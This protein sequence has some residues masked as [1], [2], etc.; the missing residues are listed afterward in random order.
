MKTPF[1]KSG[2]HFALTLSTTLVAL[3]GCGGGSNSNS[4]V[5]P[6][7]NGTNQSG[8]PTPGGVPN[9]PILVPTGTQCAGA[10]P[11]LTGTPTPLSSLMDGGDG[12]IRLVSVEQYQDTAANGYFMSSIVGETEVNYYMTTVGTRR[13]RRRGTALELLAATARTRTTCSDVRSSPLGTP[14]TSIEL[15][16]WIDRSNGS[17]GQNVRLTAGRS[18][19][20]VAGNGNISKAR[21]GWNLSAFVQTLNAQ[22]FQGVTVGKL[23]NGDFEVFLSRTRTVPGTAA[24][25]RS[26][27]RAVYSFSY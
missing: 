17:I 26:L 4:A 11:T 9:G 15:P 16:L 7:P 25:V 5:N 8:Y 23:P 20:Y 13:Q 3:A 24:T 6:Y 19:V 1:R 10:M 2:L 21:R 27:T 18:N 12:C 22:G 14:G